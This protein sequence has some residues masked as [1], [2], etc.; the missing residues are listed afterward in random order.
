MRKQLITTAIAA[1][2]FVLGAG[3]ASLYTHADTG[4]AVFEIYENNV[5]DEAAY[6]AAL[7]DAIKFV[8]DNGKQ[9]VGNRFVVIRYPNE[10]AQMKAQTDGLKA[11]IEKNAAWIEKNAPEAR[12]IAA[13]AWE[14][15]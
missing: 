14:M 5:T 7:P 8:K 10:A 9:A 3:G 1:A 12:D 15:K 6:K 2:C 11:W 4:P 13:Q